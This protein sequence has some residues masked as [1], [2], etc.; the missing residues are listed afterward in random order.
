MRQPLRLANPAPALPRTYIYCTED[1]DG[2]PVPPY[3]DRV[4]TDP[5][6]RFVELAAGHTAHVAAPETLTATLLSI[7]AVPTPAA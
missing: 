2:E 5:S 1:K 7:A 4:R 6:W 3:L